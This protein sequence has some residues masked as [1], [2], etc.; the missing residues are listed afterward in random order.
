MAHHSS[1]GHGWLLLMAMFKSPWS[2]LVVPIDAANWAAAFV[3][4]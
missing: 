4:V 2:Y 1:D 3:V